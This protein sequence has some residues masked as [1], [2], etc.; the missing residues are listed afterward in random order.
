MYR[1]WVKKHQVKLVGCLKKTNPAWVA[2]PD[3]WETPIN[4]SEITTVV[5][6]RPVKRKKKVA[7]YVG[8]KFLDVGKEMF[9]T[10]G[11]QETAICTVH[12]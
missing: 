6:G 10:L 9:D 5:G 7:V 12:A 11:G 8:D 2:A 4:K 3:H 1:E